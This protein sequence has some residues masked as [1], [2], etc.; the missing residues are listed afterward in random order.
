MNNRISIII[1]VY[2]AENY[3]RETLD[4]FICQ[5]FTDWQMILVNDGSSDKSLDIIKE[6]SSKDSRI[7]FIDKINEGTAKA[8]A[9]GIDAATG[10]YILSFD[11]DDFLYPDA[12][13]TLYNLAASNNADIVAIPFYF[14]N[15]D[16]SRENSYKLEFTKT[17]GISYLNDLFCNKAHWPLWANF[18]KTSLLKKPD[19]DF[20]HG[21]NSGEDMITLVQIIDKDTKIV[22][23]PVPL[24]DYK[25]REDSVSRKVTPRFYSELGKCLEFAENS[26]KRKRGGEI[27]KYVKNSIEKAWI[28]HYLHEIFWGC[29]NKV[30]ENLKKA[31]YLLFRHPS[32]WRM[33]P[34]PMKKLMKKYIFHPRKGIER[35]HMLANLYTTTK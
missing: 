33:M 29:D 17:D 22:A 24:I 13:E 14:L 11:S 10:K 15:P 31:K 12:L 7:S 18:I 30:P 9:A 21:I 1:P 19:I 28:I 8:R 25:V 23:C 2:N 3:L 32:A 20:S 34:E 4:S 5:T 16:G 6:Y 27:Y 35:A 26:L